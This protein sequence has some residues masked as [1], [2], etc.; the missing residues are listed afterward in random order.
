MLR[1]KKKKVGAPQG[2]RDWQITRKTVTAKQRRRSEIPDGKLQD[3][4]YM[5]LYSCNNVSRCL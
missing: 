4:I 5:I 3:D 1:K 2:F